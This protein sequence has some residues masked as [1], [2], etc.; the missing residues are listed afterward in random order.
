MGLRACAGEC[1]LQNRK[2]RI[3][4]DLKLFDTSSWVLEIWTWT[5]APLI[6]TGSGYWS[7][8]TSEATRILPQVGPETLCR[9]MSTSKSQITDLVGFEVL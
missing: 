5:R 9:G 6:Q 8:F 7:I 2:L 4:S 3:K 1:Q